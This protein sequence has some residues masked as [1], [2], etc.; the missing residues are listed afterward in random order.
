MKIIMTQ[1]EKQSM[2]VL[3]SVVVIVAS[4]LFGVLIGYYSCKS[5][6]DR[7][8]RA[9]QKD[10]A[11]LEMKLDDAQEKVDKFSEAYATYPQTY[12][13]LRSYSITEHK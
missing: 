1:G 8:I 6:S 5:Q 2:T 9:Y 12:Y 10:M 11:Q 4:L 7:R 13:I 3:L